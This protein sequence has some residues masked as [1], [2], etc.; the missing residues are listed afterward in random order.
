MEGLLREWRIRRRGAE[1]K[2]TGE[3]REA[4]EGR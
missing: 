1:L 3:S 2:G 4:E